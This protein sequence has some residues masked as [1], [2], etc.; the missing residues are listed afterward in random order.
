MAIT[1]ATVYP[2][3]LKDPH[4]QSSKS[5][6]DKA[7][8]SGL[9]PL[10][11]KAEADWKAVSW[12]A[13]KAARRKDDLYDL[14]SGLKDS[15]AKA[16]AELEGP[17]KIAYNSL[18]AA[19]EKAHK[20]SKQVTLSKGAAL[21][22]KAMSADLHNQAQLLK[23]IKLDDWDKELADLKVVNNAQDAIYDQNLSKIQ[24]GL[25]ELRT[26]PTFDGWGKAN[27]KKRAGDT[28]SH[29]L[30]AIQVGRLDFRTR[31]ETW[32]NVVKLTN[33]A[34]NIV[35]GTDAAADKKVIKSYIT[36]MVKLLG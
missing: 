30:S 2:D 15:S 14:L 3:N 7:S 27:L 25:A 23:A 35:K 34:N 8:K 1:F 22:A 36:Q 32:F 19:S 33:A 29:V 20:V 17:V 24:D 6:L 12:D 18:K 16:K 5:K 21:V 11:K 4:W 26:N 9:G 31:K 28:N 10:L 13:M